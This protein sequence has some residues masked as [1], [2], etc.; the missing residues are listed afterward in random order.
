MTPKLGFLLQNYDFIIKSQWSP[1]FGIFK[2]FHFKFIDFS[3]QYAINADF[4]EL[5][6]CM[7][8]IVFEISLRKFQRFLT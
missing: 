6:K 7:E 1:K 8:R 3:Y 4:S 5:W 2:R